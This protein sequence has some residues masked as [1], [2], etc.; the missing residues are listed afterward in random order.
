MKALG[1]L[2]GGSMGGGPGIDAAR[3]PGRPLLRTSIMFALIAL[4]WAAAEAATWSLG[5]ASQPKLVSLLAWGW[6]YGA[7]RTYLSQRATERLLAAVSRDI[8]PRA[9]PAYLQEAAAE[10]EGRITPAR[11]ILVPMLFAVLASAATYWVLS[12]EMDTSDF[13]RSPEWLFGT[14]LYFLSFFVSARSVGAARF[15]LSLARC[16]E[17]EPARSL[18]VLGASESALIK[19]LAG[20]GNRVLAFWALVFLLI[21][22]IMALAHPDLGAYRFALDSRLLWVLV[23]GLGFLTLGLGSVGYLQGEA[24]I[25]ATLQ[26]FTKKQAAILQEKSNDLF[27]PLCG[28]LP[29]DADEVERLKQ[30]TDWHDRILAGGHFGSRAGTAVSIALPLLLPAASLVKWFVEMLWPAGG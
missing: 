8:V 21:L 4:L 10:I 11:R 15:Y 29:K 16:L 1:R 23:P 14:A 5:I 9:S 22:P 19:G 2:L 20:L 6:C 25:H 27:D 7:A 28:R 3:L 13:F 12:Q 18:Y 26:C 30:L 24:K 17:K